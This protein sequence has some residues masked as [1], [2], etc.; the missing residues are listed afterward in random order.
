MAAH[1][2]YIRGRRQRKTLQPRSLR[3][4][5][6]RAARSSR[7]RDPEPGRIDASRV[8]VNPAAPISILGGVFATFSLV[9]RSAGTPHTS[10][11]TA[12]AAP[13]CE[14]AD[15]DR[16]H[17]AAG[18]PRGERVREAATLG[19]RSTPLNGPSRP[20]NFIVMGRFSL[21]ASHRSVDC[22]RCNGGNWFGSRGP[23]D[24]SSTSW[25]AAKRCRKVE[26]IEESRK[27]WHSTITSH[28][29]QF[30]A[31]ARGSSSARLAAFAIHETAR[32][33]RPWR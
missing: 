10:R 27:S 15:R 1:L 29:L 7:A 3:D 19:R 21:T 11:T 17:W 26:V 30:P 23:S 5:T 2:R 33:G 28:A 18:P 20:A 25:V 8:I 6:C 16:Q 14:A 12:V 4:A 9:A 24:T 31:P 32:S 22:Q 13:A